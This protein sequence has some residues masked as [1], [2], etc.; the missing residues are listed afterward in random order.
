MPG[1]YCPAC[2]LLLCGGTEVKGSAFRVIE[3]QRAV[4][5][6]V[7]M[8]EIHK[9]HI[10]QAEHD[11]GVALYRDIEAQLDQMYERIEAYGNE[12]GHLT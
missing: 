8:R 12:I 7:T 6:I 4:D 10:T 11:E 3:A 2:K 9:D 5:N 1:P